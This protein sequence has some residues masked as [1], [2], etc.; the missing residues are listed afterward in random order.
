MLWYVLST[1]VCWLQAA[2]PSEHVHA[3]RENLP[4]TEAATE[5]AGQLLRLDEKVLPRNAQGERASQSMAIWLTW[6][7]SSYLAQHQKPAQ[8]MQA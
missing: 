1:N 5:Y 3:I 6:V 7:V 4:V 2:I 8:K